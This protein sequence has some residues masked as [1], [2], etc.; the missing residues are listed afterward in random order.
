MI[1]SFQNDGIDPPRQTHSR[2][3]KQKKIVE[4][5][6]ALETSNSSQAVG[7]PQ[8][9]NDS[10]QDHCLCVVTGFGTFLRSEIIAEVESVLHGVAGVSSVE[11]QGDVPK[12]CCVTLHFRKSVRDVVNKQKYHRIF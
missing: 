8:K 4:R 12:I 5:L 7:A 3:A 6:A 9:S 10:P 11:V 1:S 2:K